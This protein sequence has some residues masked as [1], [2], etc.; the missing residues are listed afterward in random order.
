MQNHLGHGECVKYVKSFGLPT[1]V[2]GGGGYTIRNVSRCWA[3]ETSV[4]LE[5]NVS[6]DIPFNEYF[7]YYAPSFKLH[8]DP[9]PELENCNSRTFLE[10][11]KYVYSTL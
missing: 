7:E 9:N 4:L 3:F 11:I 5:E 6:N 8:L 10:D 2:L 1:M